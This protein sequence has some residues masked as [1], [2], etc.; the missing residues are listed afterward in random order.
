LVAA[1]LLCAGTVA[2]AQT[3]L[4]GMTVWATYYGGGLTGGGGGGGGGWG[5]N[6]PTTNSAYT[7]PP[8]PPFNCANHL[9]NRPPSCP[10]R[11]AFPNGP[12]YYGGNLQPG[13][14]LDR[15]REYI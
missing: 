12:Q 11:P 6:N 7:N 1:A 8:Q 15:I 14:A 9:A 5:A 2:S 3:T 10:T 4:G 13:S